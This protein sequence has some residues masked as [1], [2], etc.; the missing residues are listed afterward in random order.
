SAFETYLSSKIA[1][2]TDLVDQSTSDAE[3][4]PEGRCPL[5]GSAETSP[6]LFLPSFY[7]SCGGGSDG[8]SSGRR[9]VV[10][11]NS[12]ESRRKVPWEREAEQKFS[13]RK[14]GVPDRGRGAGGDDHRPTRDTRPDTAGPG[15]ENGEG[16]AHPTPANRTRSPG[17]PGDQPSPTADAETGPRWDSELTGGE[18]RRKQFGDLRGVQRRTLTQ[19]VPAQEQ[20]QRPRV[21]DRTTDA[22]HPGRVGADH[23]GRGRELPLGRIVLHDHPGRGGQQ[24]TGLVG[25]HLGG[26]GRVDRERVSG[27]HRHAHTGRRHPKIRKTEDLAGLVADLQLLRRP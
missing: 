12:R 3:C 6:R 9:A 18:L 14:K 26:E 25:V 5:S 11:P 15:T 23:V 16:G 8:F 21:V 27:D 19:V 20:V 1:D 22:P 2:D 13:F 4:H 24:P 17:R 7:C 10:P